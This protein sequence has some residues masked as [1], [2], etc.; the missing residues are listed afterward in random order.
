MS[1][2]SIQTAVPIGRMAEYCLMNSSIFSLVS[3]DIPFVVPDV[4]VSVTLIIVTP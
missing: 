2:A 3:K 1:G 4:D